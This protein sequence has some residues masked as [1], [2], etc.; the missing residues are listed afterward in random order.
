M[1]VGLFES[2]WFL[3]LFR[4]CL[5][6]GFLLAALRWVEWRCWSVYYPTVLF[7]MV[8]DTFASYVAYLHPLWVFNPDAVVK[9]Q[10]VVELVS[11]FVVMPASI[12]T[13]LSRFPAG[14]LLEQGAYVLAWAALFGSLE[15]LDVILVNGISYANGWSLAHSC[16]F[17]VAMFAI[18]G[19]H[20]RRPLCGW[21]ATLA[22]AVYILAAFGFWGAEMK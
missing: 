19:L 12:L 5:T 15:G 17:D 7:V 18:I 2:P 21:L 11:I 13:Y 22:L 3:L 1:P 10:T 16:I 20:Y 8:V 14:G 6:G 4:V 9:S